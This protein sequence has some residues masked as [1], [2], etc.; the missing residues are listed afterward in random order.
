MRIE[1]QEAI[2]HDPYYPAACDIITVPDE[3]GQ[4][5][6]NNGWAMNVD[7]GEIGAREGGAVELAIKNSKIGIADTGA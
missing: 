7:T 5:F 6:V 1:A 4:Y 3:V 2:K